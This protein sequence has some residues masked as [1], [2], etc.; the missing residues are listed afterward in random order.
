M[1]SAAHSHPATTPHHTLPPPFFVSVRPGVPRS[2]WRMTRRERISCVRCY[3][4][5]SLT[6]VNIV[7]NISYMSWRRFHMKIIECHIENTLLLFLV[8]LVTTDLLNFPNQFN[9]LTFCLVS[10]HRTGY[11]YSEAQFTFPRCSYVPQF[12]D[13][14]QFNGITRTN[15]TI[16]MGCS[17]N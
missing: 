16:G 17:H 11:K 12:F 9:N 5:V 10:Q 2:T 6:S 3:V 7:N 1:L 15:I 4:Y 13:A 14:T 8:G